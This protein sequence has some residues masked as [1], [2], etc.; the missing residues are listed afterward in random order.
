MSLDKFQDATAKITT[1]QRHD[2]YEAAFVFGSLAR[3]EITENSDLDVQVIT[4]EDNP[5]IDILHPFINGIKL[6]LSFLSYDQL[7]QRTKEE[8]TKRPQR[9]TMV[10]ESTI[11][12]DKTGRLTKLRDYYK[13]KQPVKLSE[14]SYGFQKFLIYHANQKVERNL[15]SNPET[16][17]LAMH[18]GIGELL[19]IHYGVHGHWWVSDK[20]LLGDLE[21]WDK[22]LF[23]LVRRFVTEAEPS[24]KFILWSQIVDHIA[25][26]IGG[27]RDISEPEII[28]EISARGLTDMKS[29]I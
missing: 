10:G 7:L 3:E 9:V 4:L 19:Q 14:T 25:D 22:K 21:S 5:S 20:R 17:L 26:P 24:E 29:S 6:D 1:L 28:S 15:Q 12:F 13:D 18:V 8:E 23:T 11:L 16:A 2:Y 27:H